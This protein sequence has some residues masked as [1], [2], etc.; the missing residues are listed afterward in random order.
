M[1]ELAELLSKAKKVVVLTGAGISTE[2]GIPDFRSPG[3]IW[4]RFRIIEYRE[5]MASEDARLE[6][7]RR[8]FYME[9]QLGEVKPNIAHKVIADWVDTGKCSKLITQNIDGLHQEAGTK[10]G[11]MIEIHGSARHANCTE[12]GLRHEISECRLMLEEL[13]SSPRCRECEG[14]IK[15]AVVMFGEQMP[16]LE[17]NLAFQAAGDCDLFL[18]IGTSLVVRPVASLPECAISAGAKFAIINRD[19][20]QLDHLANVVVNAGIGETMAKMQVK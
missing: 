14:I 20:T 13:G 6:D 7:W 1:S 3:G 5:F 17:T 19:N 9:D 16:L 15:S 11:A 12:C 2:S 18:A 4:E 10:T 8:R